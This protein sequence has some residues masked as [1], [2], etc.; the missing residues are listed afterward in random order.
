[1]W[2]CLVSKGVRDMTK[3]EEK[4]IV[5]LGA[6]KEA[7]HMLG[8]EELKNT[9]TFNDGDSDTFDCVAVIEEY[10][11]CMLHDEEQ[12]NS[13]EIKEVMNCVLVA[14]FDEN[15]EQVILA[16]LRSQLKRRGT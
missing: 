15:K 5:A 16:K 2:P 8:V 6:V 7:L 1:M 13:E 11:V 3:D 12:L 14:C 9:I 4:L 10:I